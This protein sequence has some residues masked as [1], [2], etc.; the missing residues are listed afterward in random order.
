[1]KST[2][3]MMMLAVL[4][5]GCDGLVT[6]VEPDSGDGGDV[7]VPQG[8]V[9]PVMRVID[10]DTIEVLYEG[11]TESVRY[12]G[13]NTPERDEPC[14]AEARQANLD[15]V[16]GQDVT[17]VQDVTDRDRF[18]RLLRYIY[19][20]DVFVERELVRQGYAE[21]VLYEPDDRHYADLLEL[22]KEAAA[23]GLGCHP[24][25]IFDDGSDVR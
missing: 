6:P 14:Y 15:L 7:S 19:V 3:L 16:D 5:A 17:L 11:V 21:A 4:L 1:M 25:G 18:G 10:G 12:V 22:E 8:D 20:G 9:V 13:I 2:L 24:T 23:A